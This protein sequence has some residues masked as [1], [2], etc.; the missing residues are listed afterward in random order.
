MKLEIDLEDLDLSARRGQALIHA[1]RE[2][3]DEHDR[4]RQEM[5]LLLPGDD[6]FP[7][8]LQRFSASA[9]RVAAA[10]DALAEF[11][12]RLKSQLDLVNNLVSIANN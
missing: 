1:F 6:R 11:R 7:E 9:R 10:S 12:S 2:A 8:S 4:I 3:I 5:L